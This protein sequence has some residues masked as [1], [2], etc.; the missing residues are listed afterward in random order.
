MGSTPFHQDQAR[1]AYGAG[2]VALLRTPRRDVSKLSR[3]EGALG[4][5]LAWPTGLSER[6]TAAPI[7]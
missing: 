7:Y 1:G 5:V 3:R 2:V 6:A 4:L